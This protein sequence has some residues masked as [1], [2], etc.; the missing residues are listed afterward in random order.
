MNDK[1]KSPLELIS[2]YQIT[3]WFLSFKS[4]NF[5]NHFRPW[6]YLNMTT[7]RQILL[8]SPSTTTITMTMNMMDVPLFKWGCRSKFIY[9]WMVWCKNKKSPPMNTLSHCT[10][11]FQSKIWTRVAGQQG[12]CEKM[13][14]ERGDNICRTKAFVR[15]FRILQPILT[16]YLHRRPL[17]HFR[18]FAGH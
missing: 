9:T 16:S 15:A 18:L 4:P 14:C 6:N 7:I 13:I 10:K 5:E 1:K 11:M 2:F 12:V 17:V 8:S 3:N